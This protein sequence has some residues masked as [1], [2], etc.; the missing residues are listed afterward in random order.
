MK[1]ALA[2]LI[3]A[4]LWPFPA[5]AQVKVLAGDEKISV[6]IGGKPFTA[7]FIRGAAV[8][9]PYLHPLRAASATTVTRLFPMEQAEGDPV[10]HPHQRGLWIAH[11]KVNNLD[12]WNNEATY[13]TPNRGKIALA[14][15][16]ALKSGKRGSISATFD[17]TDLEGNKVLTESRT[18]VF[19]DGPKLR[20]VDFDVIFTA[21]VKA[22]FHDEKDGFFGLRIRPGLQES[23]GGHIANAE[24]L[25]GEK[26]MWGKP[27]NWVDYYGEVNGE[28]LGIAI[29]DHPGNPHH[30]VRWHA[31]A[32]GL[33]AAN[34]FGLAVFT[35]DK[36][37]DGSLTLEPGQSA[38]FRY[39][40]IVH[41]GDT[42]TAGIAGLWQ[43][44][45]A[46]K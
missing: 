27:S 29:L 6:E 19:Y 42:A 30:P 18:M 40:V 5:A 21:V 12:F 35:H 7:F 23:K 39:R 9:K 38:R 13:K 20:I 31:R 44:Y 41:P 37:Q 36:S 43:K 32:Y 25:I 10:D 28:K 17:W 1:L 3:S 46:A 2:L 11:A 45:I 15:L 24:G 4:T 33:F 22:V 26:N 16:G 8:M 14:K 34:P